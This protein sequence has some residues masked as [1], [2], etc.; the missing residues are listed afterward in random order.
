[1]SVALIFCCNSNWQFPQLLKLHPIGE[2]CFG[3]LVFA[4]ACAQ[5]QIQECERFGE[6]RHAALSQCSDL[7]SRGLS[8]AWI[9]GLN[10]LHK[11]YEVLVIHANIKHVI[12][13]QRLTVQNS[14]WSVSQWL[15]CA[16]KIGFSVCPKKFITA[17]SLMYL[18]YLCKGL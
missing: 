3:V 16:I 8:G 2:G 10:I 17:N 1:M 7:Q 15:S 13:V 14:H 9:N 5:P 11:F 4:G 18:I 6:R 12:T